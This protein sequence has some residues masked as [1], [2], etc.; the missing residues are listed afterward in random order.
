LTP[1]PSNLDIPEIKAAAAEW[2]LVS[3]Q[4]E[5]MVHPVDPYFYFF[6]ESMKLEIV[7]I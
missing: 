3:S 2:A 4:I 6:H 5:K 7:P 1:K